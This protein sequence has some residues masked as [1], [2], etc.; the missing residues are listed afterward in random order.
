MVFK[1]ACP[2][3][4]AETVLD[5]NDETAARFQIAL[6]LHE[7]VVKRPLR[8]CERNRIFEHADE[9]DNIICL[10]KSEVVEI[11]NIDGEVCAI[12]V[13]IRRNFCTAR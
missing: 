4:H 7:E 12:L 5:S 11:S 2:I 9:R 10:P 8:M 6:T 3:L 13:A 1:C